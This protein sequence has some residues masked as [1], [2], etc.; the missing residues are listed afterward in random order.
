MEEHVFPECSLK[1]VKETRGRLVQQLNCLFR[2]SEE[3]T[4]ILPLQM[5]PRDLI[6]KCV[7]QFAEWRWYRR[8]LCISHLFRGKVLSQGPDSSLNAV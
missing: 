3:G 4:E 6:V 7:V 8:E 1:M 2:T 5:Q